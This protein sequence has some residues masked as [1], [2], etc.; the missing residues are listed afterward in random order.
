MLLGNLVL[1]PLLAIVCLSILEVYHY[2]RKLQLFLFWIV[3][4]SSL[5]IC[6]WLIKLAPVTKLISQYLWRTPYHTR[7][8]F[9][10]LF[11]YFFFRLI[12]ISL[13]P[14]SPTLLPLRQSRTEHICCSCYVVPESSN[15]PTCN[16]HVLWQC[17]RCQIHDNFWC[18]LLKKQTNK[19]PKQIMDV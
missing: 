19:K 1:A 12:F 5:Y 9:F 13:L 11:C 17:N 6:C 7:Q 15:R 3:S 8:G 10:F 4:N 16:T 2:L 18:S 14:P